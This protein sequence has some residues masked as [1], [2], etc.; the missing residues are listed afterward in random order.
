MHKD[1]LAE[2][3]W[4]LRKGGA[5]LLK[6]VPV[7][8]VADATEHYLCVTPNEL[9]QAFKPEEEGDEEVEAARER[10]GGGVGVGGMTAG[11]GEVAAGMRQGQQLWL[12]EGSTGASQ[13]ELARGL[14][15][16]AEVVEA[17][18]SER[19]VAQQWIHQQQQRQEQQQQQQQHHQDPS[20]LELLRQLPQTTTAQPMH[21][22]GQ[23]RPTHQPANVQQPHKSKAGLS[24]LALAAGKLLKRKAAA[25][26]LQ[27]LAAP[28]PAAMQSMSTAEGNGE[29]MDVNAGRSRVEGTSGGLKGKAVETNGVMARSWPQLHPEQSQQEHQPVIAGAWPQQQQQSQV[30]RTGGLARGLAAALARKNSKSSD[31]SRSG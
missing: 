7:L 4:A 25:V 18:Q 23:P 1:V 27:D 9:V 15:E 11:T 3:P 17:L 24:A 13:P 30:A 14:Q 31:G 6:D 8:T 2:E 29:G 22:P 16:K 5:L 19:E 20:P 12:S 28:R 21:Q 26:P 10:A